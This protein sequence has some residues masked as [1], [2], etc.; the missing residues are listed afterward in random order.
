[1]QVIIRRT[2]KVSDG[3]RALRDALRKQGYSASVKTGNLPGRNT[4]SLIINWACHDPIA[5]VQGD[6]ILNVGDLSVA[7]DKKRTFNK[8]RENQFDNIPDFWT[9]PPTEE[10]RGK[11]I[12]VER[13]TTT[14]EGGAGINIKRPGDALTPNVPLYVRY[15]RKEIEL[16]VHVIKGEAV[17]V[18]QKRKKAD[19]QQTDDQQLVRN[20]DNG[21]I[22]AT[23]DVDATAAT[24]AKPVAVE[25]M[26]ILG[27]DFGA[28]DIVIR[29]KDG[30]PMVLEVNTKPGIESDTVLAAYVAKLIP[31]IPAGAVRKTERKAKKAV[32]KT[33]APKMVKKQAFR[34]AQGR[35]AKTSNEKVKKADGSTWKWITTKKG[36][37]VYR[38]IAA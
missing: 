19:A 6:V 32:K 13:T 29:K 8:L 22:F 17:A 11:D 37:R 31:M 27:I 5:Q 26:R 2:G 9:H 30:K 35:P 4:P 25:A 24:A 28:L 20:Y 23:N 34:D 15:V 18:Q 12:I 33:A 14:G 36:N 21:W 1:M 3:A 10:Q 7:Q 16:R 38:Q